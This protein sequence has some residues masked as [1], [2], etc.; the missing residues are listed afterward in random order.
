[1]SLRV[2]SEYPRL[3]LCLLMG[4]KL[5]GT[6][7]VTGCNVR[8]MQTDIKGQNCQWGTWKG[9]ESFHHAKS[10]LKGLRDSEDFNEQWK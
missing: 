4:K 1:M 5:N 8:D 3:M 9:E 10:M 2:K 6:S 7:F